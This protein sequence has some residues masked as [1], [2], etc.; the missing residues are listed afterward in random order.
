MM[1]IDND[2]LRPYNQEAEKLVDQ[3]ESKLFEEVHEHALAFIPS[4]QG[5]VLDIGAGSGRDASWFESHGHSVVAVEPAIDLRRKAQSIH[6][7]SRIKWVD[8][9]LPSLNGTFRLACQYDL[10]WV[11][12][13]WMHLTLNERKASLENFQR[14]LAPSGRIMVSL[15]HG[16]APRNRKMYEVS[17]AELQRQ[18]TVAGF[19]VV[20]AQDAADSF[21]RQG[22][23]WQTVVLEHA[24]LKDAG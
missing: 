21:K 19:R 16:P 3:Y 9:H 23:W 1:T 22:V 12:A 17:L 2:I 13:V 8:D 10:I 18:S 14:L 11:S 24:G 20:F 5:A 6:P 4:H 7:G 15:R